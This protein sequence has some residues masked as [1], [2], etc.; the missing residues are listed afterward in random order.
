LI[1][2]IVGIIAAGVLIVAIAAIYY[3]HYVP[4]GFETM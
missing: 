4:K 2:I 1:A 3:Y